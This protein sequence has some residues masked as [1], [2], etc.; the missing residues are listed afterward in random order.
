MRGDTTVTEA[1]AIAGGFNDR[2]KHSQVLVFRRVSP[3]WL[4]ARTVNVKAILAGKQ[5]E[6]LHIQPGDMLFVPQNRISKI[7]PYLPSSSLGT[8]VSPR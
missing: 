6:D 8:Y 1:L 7:K 4:R 5:Q 3:D 2:A